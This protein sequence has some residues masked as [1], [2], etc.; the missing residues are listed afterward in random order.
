MIK[1]HWPGYARPV[2][3]RVDAVAESE[4]HVRHAA[5]NGFCIHPP[6][7]LKVFSNGL[8]P[9]LDCHLASRRFLNK[10]HDRGQT[11]GYCVPRGARFAIANGTSQRGTM[12]RRSQTATGA[13]IANDQTAARRAKSDRRGG[14]KMPCGSFPCPTRR[15][16]LRPACGNVPAR[17]RVIRLF[18]ILRDVAETRRRRAGPGRIS[19]TAAGPAGPAA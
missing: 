5:G 17:L 2:L 10:S 4:S 19:R 9:H 18:P 14:W 6:T 12:R 7:Y 8:A 1:P 16:K 3:A 13:G 15:F 11:R